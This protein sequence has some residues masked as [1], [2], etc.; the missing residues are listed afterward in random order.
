MTAAARA[1]GLLL[2]AALL[3]LSGCGREAEV[4]L[5]IAGGTVVDGTGSPAVRAD[6]AILDG[7]IARVGDLDGVS[8]ARTVD[9]TGLVVAPGF[10]DPHTHARRGLLEIPTADPY[11]HQGVTTV[12]EGN[13]GSSPLP[14]APYLDSIAEREV[15]PNFALFV[16]HG[17][18]RSEV[19]GHEDRPPSA[20]EIAE[21]KALVARGM[22]DG[23]LGLSTGLA[24]VPGTYATTEE[25]IELA[26]VA[27]DYGGIYI[28][29]MRDEGKGVL[30]SVRETIRIG[31]EAGIPVQMTHH[32]VGGH[33]QFGQS[34]ESVR[35]MRAARARGVD[36]TF[37]QYPY[38]ASSTGL[39]FL[40]PAW[41]LAGDRLQDRLA[42][43][44]ERERVFADMAA[45]I[46]ERFANDASRI[47]L[48]SCVFDSTLAGRT[49]EQVLRDR[50]REPTPRAIS[51]IVL[52][53]HELGRCGSILHSYDEA[54][55][56]GFLRSEY[57]MIGSDGSLGRFGVGSPHPRAYGTYPRVL[58]RYVRE[59]GVLSLEEAV[60][61]MT[62]FPADRLG[63]RDRGR[64][65]EGL[66]ADLTVFDPDRVEDRAT[67][68]DPHRYS[69]GIEHV[70]VAGVPV[71]ESG[72][73]TGARPGRVLRGPAWREAQ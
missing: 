21:L 49:L 9:A 35:L 59:R 15:S 17:S 38:T 6:V 72:R 50:G 57:G 20:A 11:L 66:V 24:Y 40:I 47:Q 32:K 64:I 41:A 62:S 8:A 44:A 25:V 45:F 54:D 27:A 28:S 61:K 1:S 22:E 18:I 16:G 2:A 33:R 26:K 30:D 71:I 36:V 5:L 56:E 69:V 70:F 46:D 53:F 52:E 34:A 23:A 55:V 68:Q 14:I 29:H 37:D 12:V 3:S 7:R 43:A 31:E 13:D 67:F 65:A 48:V 10:I 4:D 51:G 73:H 58:S 19:M 63:F 60:R 42:D 39:S